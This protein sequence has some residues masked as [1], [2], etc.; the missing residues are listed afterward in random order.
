MSLS[1]AGESW[2]TGEY[3][4]IL[5]QDWQVMEICRRTVSGYGHDYELLQIRNWLSSASDHGASLFSCDVVISNQGRGE[6]A[7]T[8]QRPGARRK[9]KYEVSS[10]H[11]LFGLVPPAVTIPLPFKIHA[12][13]ASSQSTKAGW[14]R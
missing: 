6:C 10:L 11:N 12:L 4:N 8:S 9:P 5:K 14:K 2:R 7:S 3:L 1:H 13:S